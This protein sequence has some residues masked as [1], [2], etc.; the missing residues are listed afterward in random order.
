MVWGTK[1]KGLCIR[2][3]RDEEYQTIGDVS[4]I[5]ANKISLFDNINDF[6]L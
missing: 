5:T 3:N 1:N 4:D 6:Q 2:W